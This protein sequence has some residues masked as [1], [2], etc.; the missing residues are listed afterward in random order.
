MDWTAL[1]KTVGLCLISIIIELISYSKEGK[2]WFEKLKQPKYSFPFSF[3]YVVGGLY[4][5]ICGVIA[6][7]Q[8]HASTE[9]FTLPIILLIVMMVIN[10]L[11]NFILFKFRSLKLFVWVSFPFTCLLI[12]LI[13]TLFQTDKISA[14]LAGIYLLWLS[15]DFYYFIELLKLNRHMTINNENSSA[16]RDTNHFG[17]TKM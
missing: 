7:R 15:Y 12:W 3:W 10:G 2:T 13:I 16:G 6:Y 11:S 8:F 17:E 14:I 5:I 4:Y 1:I 9:T